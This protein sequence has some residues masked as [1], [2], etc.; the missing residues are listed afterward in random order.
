MGFRKLHFAA[1]LAAFFLW[2]CSGSG[3][4]SPGPQPGSP[5]PTSLTGSAPTSTSVTLTWSGQF[6]KYHIYR[7]DVEVA[8]STATSY[9]DTGL[10]ASTPYRYFVRGESGSGLSAPSATITVTTPNMLTLDLAAL[11]DPSSRSFMM[12]RDIEFDAAGNIYVTGGAFSANFPTTPGAYDRTFSSGG[13]STGS[14]GPS[15]VFVMKLNRAG[16]VIWSTLIGG[17]NHD[18]AYGLEVL[19]DGSVVVA[20]RAGEGF[21]TTPGVI[22]PAFAGDN[23][24]VGAY[25]KQDGFIAKLSADGSTLLWSTYFGDAGPGVLRDVGVDSN[26]KIY[27]AGASFG[28]LGFITPNAA[29]STVRG[30]HDLVYAR[31]NQTAT[32]VEYATYLGG[33]EPVGETPGTPS[34]TV[35]PDRNVYV[36]IEEGGNGAPTTANAYRQTSAGG[37]DFLIARFSP[38]DQLVFATYLGGAGDEDLETHNIA[39]DASG[40]VVIASITSSQNY[41]V[42]SG[43]Y[44]TQYGGGAND[45]VVSVLSSDGRTLAASTFIGGNGGEDLQGVEFA[46][47][48]LIYFSGGSQSSSLRTTSNAFRANFSGVSDAILCAMTPDL[49]GAP[50]LTYIGGTGSEVSRALDVASDGAVA[51]GGVTAS[52]NF[53]VTAGGS[54]APNGGADTGWFAL[55]TH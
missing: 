36:A 27:V 50:Y 54:T 15:D 9:T 18:R 28:G 24:P 55:L 2:G 3:S 7:N 13:A 5:T 32:G 34:I 31:L 46:P 17:P 6:S 30:S 51:I 41:P 29:Q 53:P 1:A 11:V 20:G 48:G 47:D 26:N 16:Q 14:V 45:G 43:A 40:K 19:A 39:V 37:V 4:G 35:T 10:L 52:P 49:K 21:P 12:V 38:S 25:G 42:T 33:A 8:T 44:Q 22:Q 23:A